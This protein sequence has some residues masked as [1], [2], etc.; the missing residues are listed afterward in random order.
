MQL[1]LSGATSCSAPQPA[2]AATQ[3]MALKML[4][5][6]Q[7]PPGTFLQQ[8][9]PPT[10]CSAHAKLFAKC[11]NHQTHCLLALVPLCIGSRRLPSMCRCLCRAVCRCAVPHCSDARAISRRV[12]AAGHDLMLCSLAAPIARQRSAA[13]RMDCV[14]GSGPR[15]KPAGRCFQSSGSARGASCLD[16]PRRPVDA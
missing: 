8:E 2:A 10:L 6:P 9:L 11:S 7:L 3:T 1:Y 15:P 13:H 4:A 12:D 16:G 14:N 5:A